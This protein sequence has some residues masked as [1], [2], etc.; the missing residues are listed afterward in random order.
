MGELGREEKSNQIHMGPLLAVECGSYSGVRGR[1]ARETGDGHNA[2]VWAAILSASG[3]TGPYIGGARMI[4][5]DQ[6]QAEPRLGEGWGRGETN[7]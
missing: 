6:R 5:G 3:E 1:G 2:K 4:C 7:S